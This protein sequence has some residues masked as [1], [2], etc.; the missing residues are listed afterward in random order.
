MDHNQIDDMLL[1][2][3]KNIKHN[4]NTMRHKLNSLNVALATVIAPFS[5]VSLILILTGSMSFNA[6]LITTSLLL[7]FSIMIYF[8][9]YLYQRK[10]VAEEYR[11]LEA[12]TLLY[13]FDLIQSK[14][15][16][17]K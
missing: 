2:H 6:F 8:W 1:G 17:I 12:E 4:K 11:E 5:I 9:D 7:L 3:I 16:S 14:E 10:D 13:Y 15:N